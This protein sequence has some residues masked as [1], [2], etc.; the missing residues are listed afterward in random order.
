M[1]STLIIISY[2]I[3]AIVIIVIIRIFFDYTTVDY[4]YSYNPHTIYDYIIIGAG[5][6]GSVMAHRL[7]EYNPCSKILL[8]ERGEDYSNCPKV[9]N[10][11]KGGLIAG[12]PPYSESLTNEDSSISIKVA[13]MMGGASSHNYGLVVYGSEAYYKRE[14]PHLSFEQIQ[15]LVYKIKSRM[16]TYKVPTSIN[17]IKKIPSFISYINKNPNTYARVRTIF[18]SLNTYK[19]IGDL[20]ASTSFSELIVKALQSASGNNLHELHNYNNFSTPLGVDINNTLFVNKATGLRHSANIGYLN[21]NFVNKSNITLVTGAQ[22]S[23]ICKYWSTA[24]TVTPGISHAI[25]IDTTKASSVLWRD[26]EGIPHNSEIHKEGKIILCA[27]AIYSPTL[28]L[29]SGFDLEPTLTTHY[30]TTLIFRIPSCTV[31][32]F[33][34]GPL[35]F[36]NERPSSVEGRDWQLIVG[37]SSLTN[38]SLLPQAQEE[39]WTYVNL[40]LWLLRPRSRGKLSLLPP[41]GTPDSNG[42]IKLYMIGKEDKP[43]IHFP[44]FSDGDINDPLSDISRCVVGMHFMKSVFDNIKSYIP[45]S[46]LLFPSEI[47]FFPSSVNEFIAVVKKGVTMTDHYCG[48]CKDAIHNIESDTPLATKEVS[49][50]HVVDCSAFKNIS[51]GNTEFPTLMLAEHMAMRLSNM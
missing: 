23:K 30:G 49:N 46:E 1:K 27:G 26:K 37:G 16:S 45:S 32:S 4:S 3:I 42:D 20:R 22:V 33:S 17:I 50:V 14:F 5:T 11:A 35:A 38:S 47:D 8:L 15:E 18:Q 36:L 13:T 29:K 24:E 19:N 51:D 40:L 7:A 48:T 43:V 39:G 21:P 25:T 28:L 6:A 44:M 2:V 41:E 34:A 9:Y 10:T 12:N 31:D